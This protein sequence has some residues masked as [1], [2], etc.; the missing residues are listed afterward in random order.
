MVASGKKQAWDYYSSGADDE[1]TY[2][3]NVNAFQR[4]WLKPRILVNVKDVD[5]SC[6][7]L[8]HRCAM[9]VYLSAVA[10]CGMG[11]KDGECS[12]A[13]AAF[14]KDVVFM[15]PN[16]SSK[17]FEDILASRGPGQVVWLQIYVNP[18]RSVVEEQI[19][20]CEKAGVKAL[21]IT[22]DSAVAG[23][24]ER[25][26]RN[27]IALEL[28]QAK[29]QKAA[30]KGTKARKAGSY[31]NRDAALNWD[32]IAWFRSKT[33]IPIVIKGVQTGEDAVLAAG[34]GASAVI[35][36][37]HG[38][39]NCDTSRSG[40]EV[41]PE[42]IEML[43]EEGVRDKLEVWVDGGI[44]RG[45]DIFKALCLGADAV[46]LGKPAV[47]AMSAYGKEGIVKMLDI[48]HT[49]LVKV[50]Q[51]C[52][53]PTLAHAK[54]SMVNAKDLANHTDSVPIPA[55]PYVLKKPELNVR[56]PEYP[57][58]KDRDGLVAQIKALQK[59]LKTLDS[60]DGG[61]G[62]QKADGSGVGE[63]PKW[64]E[65]VG[66]LLWIVGLSVVQTVFST[67]YSGTLSRSAIFLIVFLVVHMLGN[68]TVFFGADAFNGYGHALHINPLLGF[69]EAYLALAFAFH[70]I[71]ATVFTF[72]KRRMIAKSPVQ[73]GM[74]AATGTLLA[75]FLVL[76][77]RAFR[78]ADNLTYTTA[79]SGPFKG[80]K[81]KD[82]YALQLELFKDPV[83]VGFYLLSIGAVGI[84]LLFG[85][86]KSVVKMKA[87]RSLKPAFE[88]IGVAMIWPLCIGFAACPVWAWY[89][90]QH[91]SGGGSTE[92]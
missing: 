12:W 21:C 8:G 18:D 23:K 43:T 10:M 48:L 30:A 78:F 63:S 22:V 11:H 79:S 80:Q 62:H 1:L 41:L 87:D 37:N 65:A 84:H 83:Q 69:I 89:L 47:Y 66:K 72:N 5:T 7:I 54:A 61:M 58:V 15:V 85:W 76:H 82:L 51:L 70:I 77:L 17:A 40:I 52:G 3:E 64:A 73:S 60:I 24:R 38:G 55:S 16:L 32:D 59:E 20:A 28:N 29:Q 57:L 88:A 44:R 9:P 4:I 71:V 13:R 35:L 26:L 46:G 49:E 34:A 42:V 75:V 90:Q 31:A 27:K 67:S 14:E 2:N 33:D 56:S 81:V 53:A 25:D 39:R 86:R 36:S 19:R 50:M 45:T 91:A 68:L 74:L 6:T 92:L